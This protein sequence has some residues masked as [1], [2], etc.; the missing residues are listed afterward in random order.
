MFKVKWVTTTKWGFRDESCAR[1]QQWANRKRITLKMC[2]FFKN[3][4]CK[5]MF[6]Q[7]SLVRWRISGLWHRRVLLVD[8]G[9]SEKCVACMSNI[10]VSY[11][12][13]CRRHIPQANKPYSWRI[14]VSCLPACSLQRKRCKRNKTEQQI[15][16]FISRCRTRSTVET[17]KARM[18][19]C[20]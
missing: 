10:K 11:V 6:S 17:V 13:G 7:R 9:N 20:N 8:I 15:C 2:R 18:L 3:L 4:R 16:A 1:I 19:L 12:P 14:N 5:I